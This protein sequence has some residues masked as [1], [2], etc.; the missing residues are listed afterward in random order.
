[1]PIIKPRLVKYLHILQRRRRNSCTESDF[2]I[3]EENF[4]KKIIQLVFDLLK[5]LMEFVCGVNP[6]TPSAQLRREPG[7][8]CFCRCCSRWKRKISEKELHQGSKIWINI[9][10]WQCLF[11]TILRPAKTQ[12]KTPLFCYPAHS[13]WSFFYTCW[14]ISHLC[15]RW[16]E[17][18]M[19]GMV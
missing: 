18:Q 9:N 10:I 2:Q 6:I 13:L 3:C 7:F 4:A 11:Y 17:G 15:R 5:Y 12:C 14:K 1:M 8:R 19:S 16:R